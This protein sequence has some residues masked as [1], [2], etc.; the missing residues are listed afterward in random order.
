[1]AWSAGVVERTQPVASPLRLGLLARV[2]HRR[3]VQLDAHALA[4]GAALGE[5]QTLREELTYRAFHDSLTGL[6]NRALLNERLEA[7]TGRHGL[8]LL[9][10]DGFKDVNDAYGHPAGDTLLIE[11]AQRLRSAV[12]EGCWCAW[13]VTS[14]PSCST[15]QTPRISEPW[16]MP[17]STSCARRSWPET[18]RPN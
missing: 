17:W 8:A 13:A 6:G 1:M 15:R 5:Q 9:D 12:A 10:L 16:P 2:A 14:S 4:L 11:V 18:A 7:V 3:A